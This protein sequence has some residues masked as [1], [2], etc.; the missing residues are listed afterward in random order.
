[1]KQNSRCGCKSISKITA[2]VATKGK[3]LT[4]EGHGSIWQARAPAGT[5]ERQTTGADTLSLSL[6]LSLHSLLPG[7]HEVI[8]HQRSTAMEPNEQGLKTQN[9]LPKLLSEK[10]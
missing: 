4:A 5:Q 10:Y 1:M 8:L 9:S 7:C 3:R 6:S 2:M